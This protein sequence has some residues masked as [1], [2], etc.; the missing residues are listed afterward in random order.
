MKN[1]S[2]PTQCGSGR[3]LPDTIPALLRIEAAAASSTANNAGRRMAP[4]KLEVRLLRRDERA[5]W[6]PL[7]KGYQ[8]FNLKK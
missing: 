7:W 4:S 1:G 3:R 2:S 8:A 5:E 6:E